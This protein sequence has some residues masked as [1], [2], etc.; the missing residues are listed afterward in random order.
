[1]KVILIESNDLLRGVLK[2][3]MEERGYEVRESKTS[4]LLET[5][6]FD[7]NSYSAVITDCDLPYLNGLTAV[8]V[9]AHEPKPVPCLV[10][11]WSKIIEKGNLKISLPTLAEEHGFVTYRERRVGATEYLWRFLQKCS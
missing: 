4:D 11:S 8:R 1:M 7:L 5:P 2:R 9:I 10:H 3:E 6:G